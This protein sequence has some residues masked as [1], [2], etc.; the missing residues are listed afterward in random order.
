MRP[1]VLRRWS[2]AI[3][4][5]SAL[6][7]F[8]VRI[9][10]GQAIVVAG[11]AVDAV[12]GRAV[13]G[14]RMTIGDI[15]VIT[16]ADGRFQLQVSA[17]RWEIDV[18]APNYAPR[19]FAFEAGSQWL[20]PLEIELIPGEGFQDRLE[21]TAP[22]PRPEGPASIPLRPRQVLS[23]ADSLDNPFR[24]LQ[25]LPGVAGTHDFGSELSLPL[26]RRGSVA[27]ES[28]T[29]RAPTVHAFACSSPVSCSR[30]SC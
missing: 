4:C 21:V 29:A 14:A 30:R 20:A 9:A 3:L 18:R 16:N 24:T 7:G 26:A 10:A 25:T 13:A 28:A 12:S 5:L 11:R 19:K 6:M 8:G 15:T 27:S 22:A 2:I 17:G 1:S 23:T